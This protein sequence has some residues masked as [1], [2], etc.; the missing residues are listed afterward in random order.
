MVSDFI[1]KYNGYLQLTNAEYE[2]ARLSHPNLWKEAR[3]LLKYGADTQNYWN[4]EKFIHHIEQAANIAE[5]KY[6]WEAHTI[7]F[8]FDKSSGFLRQ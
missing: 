8:L 7:V 4:S 1:D 3:F 5:I 6:P 2:E